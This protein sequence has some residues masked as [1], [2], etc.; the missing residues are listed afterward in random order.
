VTYSALLGITRSTTFTKKV[1]K[2][3]TFIDMS[4]G[5]DIFPM[6]SGRKARWQRGADLSVMV[7]Q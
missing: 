7:R 2:M 4:G 1:A 5:V 6:R 3:R